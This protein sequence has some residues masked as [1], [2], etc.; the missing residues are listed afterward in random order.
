[1]R[2]ARRDYDC[3][4]PFPTKRSHWV[5]IDGKTVHTDAADERHVGKHMDP[6]IPEDEPVFLIRGQDVVAPGVLRYWADCA[7]AEGA[8]KEIIDAV[9]KHA[10]LMEDW[11]DQVRSKVPDAEKAVLR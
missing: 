6:I 4:Q 5:K 11:Q 3:I 2:H 8:E 10:E 7:E 9:R 1:M